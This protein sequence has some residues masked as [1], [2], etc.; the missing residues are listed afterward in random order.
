MS[1]IETLDETVAALATAVLLLSAASA[2]AVLHLRFRSFRSRRRNRLL[3][4]NSLWP[5][6]L[7]L[8]LFAS[9][10]A[11]AEL[12]RLPLLRHL[13]RLPLPLRHDPTPLCVAHV[14]AAHALAEPCFFATVL[15]LLRASNQAKSSTPA[16]FAAALATAIPF[17]TLHALFLY[18]P[19]DLLGPP[20]FAYRV[21]PS[22]EP[23]CTY[24]L[25]GA[26]LLAALGAVYVPLFVSACWG[27]VSVVINKRLRVRLYALAAAVVAALCV[28]V[29]TLALSALWDPGKVTSEG[30]KLAAFVAVSCCAAAGEVIL[31]IQPV[32]EALAIVDPDPAGTEGEDDVTGI[33]AAGFGEG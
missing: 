31:V 19:V 10:W 24:P 18:L 2:A 11:L 6:R 22:A 25:F 26:V 3:G 14:F 1:T 8:V 20:S 5:V 17:L 30:L 33:D 4:L 7:L 29:A 27:A 32:L 16:A 9:L 13:L 21:R 15:F 12:F 23:R 28:Q